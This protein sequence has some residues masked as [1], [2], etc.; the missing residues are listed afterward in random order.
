MEKDA[1]GAYQ[2][3]LEIWIILEKISYLCVSDVLICSSL[4]FGTDIL[5]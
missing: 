5:L 1:L 3:S 4:G 2:F